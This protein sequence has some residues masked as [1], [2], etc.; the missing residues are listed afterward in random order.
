MK[1]LKRNLLALLICG[2]GLLIMLYGLSKS[3]QGELDSVVSATS[4]TEP[5]RVQHTPYVSVRAADMAY[6][7]AG[8]TRASRA[9]EEADQSA[10]SDQPAETASELEY[11]WVSVGEYTLLAYCP[12]KLCCGIWSAEHPSRIG[13]DYVQRT[14]SGTIPEAGRTIA[15]NPAVMP[16]G[17][18]VMIDGHVYIAEDTGG[19]ARRARIIDI[20][21]ECHQS[22]LEFGRQ[23]AEIFIKV[24]E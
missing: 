21:M 3:V 18:E 10:G 19:A 17:T 1:N 13:T 7:G 20:F 14:A 24:Y 22:A 15:V 11:E 6:L 8:S 5:L 16:Y 12:C 4:C 2:I 23:R 9:V